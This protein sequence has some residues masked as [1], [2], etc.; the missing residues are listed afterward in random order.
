MSHRAVDRFHQSTREWLSN[1]GHLP[2]LAAHDEFKHIE[3]ELERIRIDTLRIQQSIQLSSLESSSDTSVEGD[4]S[5][6]DYWKLSSCQ[7]P[8]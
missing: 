7:P 3:S 5:Q 2:T 1:G 6:M 8:T 4:A